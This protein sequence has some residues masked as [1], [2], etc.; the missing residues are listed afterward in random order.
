[1]AAPVDATPLLD[2]AAQRQPGAAALPKRKK[3]ERSWQEM[4]QALHSAL[5]GDTA[6][7]DGVQSILAS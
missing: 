6:D 2:V 5:N 1:M 3:R 4:I 7:V